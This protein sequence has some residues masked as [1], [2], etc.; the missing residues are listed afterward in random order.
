MGEREREELKDRIECL[1]NWRRE[2]GGES[3]ETKRFGK[4]NKEKGIGEGRGG[5]IAE[6]RLEERVK[7]MEWKAEIDEKQLRRR[8]LMFKGVKG[9]EGNLKK[10][11][12]NI[13]R[14]IGVEIEIEE[15]RSVKMGREDRGELVTVK[16]R[17][18]ENKRKIRENKGK[19]KGRDIWIEEDLTFRARK[20]RWILRRFAEEK[21]KKALRVGYGKV[22]LEGIWW[23]WNEEKELLRDGKDRQRKLREVEKRGEGEIGSGWQRES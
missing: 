2:G 4:K 1:E 11:V 18:K 9:G 12:A 23:F 7:K 10:R 22:W 16:V 14:E 17:S 20:I 19:L 15:L 3:W 8:N 13:S 5:R 21:R 6:K